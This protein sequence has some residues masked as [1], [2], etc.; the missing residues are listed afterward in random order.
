M[1]VPG[2]GDGF[3]VALPLAL[4]ITLFR[5]STGGMLANGSLPITADL[6]A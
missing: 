2:L 6:R 4:I 5:R 1:S 3:P